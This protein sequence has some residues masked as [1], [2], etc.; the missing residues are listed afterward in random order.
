MSVDE[1][2]AFWSELGTNKIHPADRGYISSEFAT[3]L[4]AMDRPT[5]T[6]RSLFPFPESWMVGR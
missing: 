3:D 2:V 5:E 4:Y 1:L 6:G